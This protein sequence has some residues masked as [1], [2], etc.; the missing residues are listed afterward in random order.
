MNISFKPPAI[1]DFEILLNWLQRPHVKKWW[2]SE[3]DYTLE[4]AKKQYSF[5]VDGC[6]RIG[7]VNKP[8]HAFIIQY[9]EQP[10]GYIQYY[11]AY[12][13]P[14]D[15]YESN[16]LPKS[17]AVIDMF[18]GD[19]QYPGKDIVGQSLELFLDTHVL[20]EFDYAFVDTDSGNSEAMEV[21]KKIGFTEVP[22][23]NNPSKI[24]MIYNSI[25]CQPLNLLTLR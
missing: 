3:T 18:I 19:D 25:R 11:N 23:K 21:Y 24:W 17:L 22:N 8:I 2:V 12:D 7:D 16:N 13:F 1:T 9:D 15:G 14:K 6:K 5:H 10:I 20:T 4:L